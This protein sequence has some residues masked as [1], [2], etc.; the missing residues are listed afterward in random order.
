MI[1]GALVNAVFCDSLCL[2]VLYL[3]LCLS[4]MSNWAYWRII[5]C[6]FPSVCFVL[7]THAD[8]NWSW[9]NGDDKSGSPVVMV[10][11]G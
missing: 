10:Q 9:F 4:V 2:S 7:I 8:H 1:Y 5:K 11:W 6:C 3:S